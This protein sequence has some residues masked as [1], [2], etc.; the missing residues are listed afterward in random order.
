MKLNTLNHT[1]KNKNFLEIVTIPQVPIY[2]I[3]AAILLGGGLLYIYF[4]YKHLWKA[5]QQ[6]ANLITYF[7][8]M[9]ITIVVM[10][11]IIY[12]IQNPILREMF[13]VYVIGGAALCATDN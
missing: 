4:L 3:E 5:S 8:L 11:L 1:L 12:V 9:L 6:I 10:I 2:F 7:V 13:C